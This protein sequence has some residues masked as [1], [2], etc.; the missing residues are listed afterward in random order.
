MTRPILEVENLHL[1]LPH[2]SQDFKILHG[3]SFAIYPGEIVGLVGES[4]C[5]KSLTASAILGL[6]P[7]KHALTGRI[8]FEG[9]NLL[10]IPSH[11]LSHLRGTRLNVILQDP[12]LA[13]NPLMPIGKQLIEG[14]C[15]HTRISWREAYQ[16]G[17][18]WLTR[19]GIGDAAYRMRQ[20]PHE[21]S[22]GMKQRILIAIALI[23]QPSLLIAD[24]P[25][26]ALDLTIQVQILDLLQRLQQE[27]GMSLLLI[28]HDLGVVAHCCQ[29]V[30][31]MYAGQ[32]VETGPIE[33]IFTTPQHPYTKALLES[34]RSLTQSRDKP[35]VC[36]EGYP[37]RLHE[38]TVGCAFTPRCPSAMRICQRKNPPL[39][40]SFQ[41]SVLCWL[42]NSPYAPGAAFGLKR[43][44]QG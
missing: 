32:L 7:P 15:Y 17:I 19:V 9:Q 10:T 3:I 41:S 42:P 2:P 38:K 5:G 18:E 34:R 24:E 13:L 37:P 30:M 1:S 39:E 14:L 31:I 26:T 36:L 33:Q 44:P 11:Q 43:K 29:R 28:T 16:K 21:I 22:G 20:Y 6:L 40:Q 23:C 25:T 35:L 27:E 8:E 4:G 12:S